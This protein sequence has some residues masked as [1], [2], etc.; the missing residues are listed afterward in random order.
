M[1]LFKKKNYVDLHKSSMRPLREKLITWDYAPL[2]ISQF[3]FEIFLNII[4]N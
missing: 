2:E 3:L 1:I 4:K